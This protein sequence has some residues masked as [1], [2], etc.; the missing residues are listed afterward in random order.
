MIRTAFIADKGQVILSADYSQI[1]L[2]LVA[3]MAGIKALQQAFRDDVDI[4]AATA[5]QVF[6]IP[7][8]QMTSDYRRMAK[9]INFGIIYGISGFGLA[10]KIGTSASEAS[11]FIKRYFDRFPELKNFME[12]TKQFARDNGYVTTLYG[13]KC[14]IPGIADKN[15]ARRAGAERQAIN[16]PVQGT[17]AD[18]IKIAMVKLDRQIREGGL[19]AKMLLQVHDELVF[20]VPAERAEEIAP[21]IKREMESVGNF[22]VPLVVETGIAANWAEA[23]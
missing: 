14:F 15:P 17:A 11:Q 1:E 2:R 5:S 19:Q 6:E 20:E 13:R 22:T 7:L 21:I 23:H 9:A 10:S 4:H 12:E 18:L 8:D 3:E 16:A